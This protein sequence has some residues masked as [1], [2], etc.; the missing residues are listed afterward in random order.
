MT[1]R[2]TTHAL[3]LV[4]GRGAAGLAVQVRRLE[5]DATDLGLIV[6]DA[7]GR[8]VLAEGSAFAAGLYEV[9]FGIGAYHRAAGL[10]DA[11]AFLE[12]APVRFRVKD[13][14]LHTHLPILVSLYGYSVYR[15]G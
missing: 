9:I 4:L 7:G 8:G 14:D 11:G 2:L 3:D 13:A 12:D 15:G 6:L 10:A 5:P 1:G